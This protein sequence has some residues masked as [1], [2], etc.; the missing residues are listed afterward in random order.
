MKDKKIIISSI[1]K[2]VA[3]TASIYGIIRMYFGPLTFTYFT[4]LS[5]MFMIAVLTLFLIKDVNNIISNEK[6]TFSNNLY[7]IKFMATI[8]ITLTFFVYLVILAP[9]Y[10]GGIINSYLSGGAA[11]LCVHLIMPVISIMDF[12]F[13]DVDYKTENNHYLLAIFPPI[14]YTIFIVVSSSF[15]LRWG[16]MCAPY[17][18][19]NYKAP[20]GWFGLDLSLVG[21][22]TLGIGVF[23]MI[24]LLSIIFIF[25][26]KLFIKL[27]NIIGDKA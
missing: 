24:L 23:Y 22:E 6:I 9:T 13:F 11:S 14:I 8:S 3:I 7:I 2:L 12:L 19:L 20:T 18:F 25:I 4:I 21:E 16:N 1:M 10:D 27:R 15:G 26:G 5:N 17:N